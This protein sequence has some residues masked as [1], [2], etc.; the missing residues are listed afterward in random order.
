MIKRFI[1]LCLA[2]TLF[3]CPLTAQAAADWPENVSIQ[4]DGGIVIDGDTGTVLYG[5]NMHTP[6][7]PDRKSVV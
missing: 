4:A 1:V 2:L 7:Y 5:K 3:L 6:Y